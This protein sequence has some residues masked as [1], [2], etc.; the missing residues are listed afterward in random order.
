MLAALARAVTIAEPCTDAA[1]S[2]GS[3]RLV[4]GT[5]L[6]PAWHKLYFTQESYRQLQLSCSG[7]FIRP[8]LMQ[9]A[10]LL[11]QCS[12]SVPV[13]NLNRAPKGRVSTNKFKHTCGLKTV[14]AATVAACGSCRICGICGYMPRGIGMGSERA[15][16]PIIDTCCPEAL[17][18]TVPRAILTSCGL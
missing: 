14:V 13:I 18:E 16:L 5:Q 9:C 8:S 1:V 6:T 2:H 3:V 10:Q 12:H 15:E 17:L 4:H 11:A 7:S